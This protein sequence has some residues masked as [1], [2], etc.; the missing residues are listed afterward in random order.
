MSATSVNGAPGRPP[1]IRGLRAAVM[2]VAVLVSVLVGLGVSVAAVAAVAGGVHAAA[3]QLSSATARPVAD[4]T[5]VTEAMRIE[6]GAMDGTPGWP[7][8]TNRSWTVRKGETVTLRITS[9]DDGTAPLTGA[10][11][12]YDAVQG[13]LGGTEAVDGQPVSTVPNAD[14]AHTFT[15]V[16]LG[17]NVPIPAAPT[18]GS[19]TVVARFVAT[20][21]GR[22]LWQCYAPC[23]SGSNSMGGAMSTMGWM[24]GAVKVVP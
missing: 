13:T 21:S 19:I 3:D 5:A 8:Y 7:R 4:H 1:G 10:Q 23:G 18:G 9:F 14:I 17:L 24:E 20:R 11:T 12:M 15:V 16:G 22:F 6:T 2:V